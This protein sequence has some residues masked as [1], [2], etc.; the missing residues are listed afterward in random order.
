MTTKTRSI[1]E[2]GKQLL[3]LANHANNLEETKTVVAILLK[4][5]TLVTHL[6]TMAFGQTV[7]NIFIM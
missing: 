3:F 5:K 2:R 1:E 4:L 7:Y 6:D